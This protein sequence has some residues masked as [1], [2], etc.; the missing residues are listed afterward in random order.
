MFG[1]RKHTAAVILGLTALAACTYRPSLFPMYGRIDDRSRLAGDW[2]GEFTS[3]HP[4]R[5]GSIAFQLEPGRD[6]ASGEV[7]VQTSSVG[8]RVRYQEQGSYPRASTA[9][10]LRIR[11]VRASES[12]V[13]GVL[14]PYHDP[15][16]DCMVTTTFLGIVRGDSI[17]GEYVSRGRWTTR[18]GAWRMGRRMAARADQGAGRSP[19]R[20]ATP[21]SFTVP[22][23]APRPAPLR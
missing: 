17:I 8:Q 10:V 22:P 23:A 13:E 14:E 11:Y 12:T 6:S 5:S 16:C 9:R 3:E 18:Q 7:S 19:M 15:D 2:F 4:D 1:H 20:A 21:T